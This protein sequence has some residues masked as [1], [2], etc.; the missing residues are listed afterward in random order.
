MIEATANGREGAFRLARVACFGIAAAFVLSAGTAH[1]DTTLRFG[2]FTPKAHWYHKDLLE[3]W[4]RDVAR[5]TEGRVKVEFTAA[6]LGPMPRNFDMV[7]RGIAD[8]TAG[9]YATMPGRFRVAQIQELANG[10]ASV[11]AV[12]V[13]YWRTFERYL[14]QANEHDGTHVLAVHASA[15][16]QL[17]MTKS[18]VT[19]LADLENKKLVAP[20]ATVGKVIKALGA[21]PVQLPVTERYDAISKGVVDGGFLSTTSV[22]GWRITEFIRHGTQLAANGYLPGSFFVVVNQDRWNTI[23]EADRKAIMAVSGETFAR[24]AGRGFDEEARD[25]LKT[26]SEA[27][28]KLIEPERGLLAALAQASAFIEEEWRSA[29]RAA[30]IDPDAALALFREETRKAGSKK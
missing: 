15:P 19:K 9:V 5:V 21:V 26:I 23:G 30:R 29:A 6:P 18:A 16:L 3:P 28:V 17:F 12:S 11:E 2:L 8:V 20:S 27:G 1:A 22:P 24:K 4:A 13:A 14:Q 25:A 7:Q 10:D